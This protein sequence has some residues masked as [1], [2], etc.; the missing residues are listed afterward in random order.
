[1][2]GELTLSRNARPSPLVTSAQEFNDTL[3]VEQQVH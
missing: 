3:A 2:Q 1:M